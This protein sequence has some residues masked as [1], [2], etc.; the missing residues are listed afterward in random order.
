MIRDL[1]ISIV[2]YNSDAVQLQNCLLSALSPQAQPNVV[3]IDNS[4]TER[5]KALVTG[6]GAEY[7]RPRTNVGFGAGHNLAIRRYLGLHKYHLVLNPD[8]YFD[9]GALDSLV[10]YMD[11][12]PQIGVVIPRVF[13][14][15]G[16]L[17]HLSKLLPTP[18][19]LFFRRF[20]PGPLKRLLERRADVYEFRNFD[21][22]RTLTVPTLS[23]CFMFLRTNVFSTIG[24]FDERY[25]MYLEDVDLCRRIHREYDVVYYPQVSVFHEYAKGSYKNRS[26]LMHHVRS[27]CKYFSKWGWFFDR[28]RDLINQKA[29]SQPKVHYSVQG[30]EAESKPHSIE[31]NLCG[32]TEAWGR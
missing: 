15:D 16:R 24:L 7:L 28:E 8:V 13:Y 18:V 29:L 4:E 27:A 10:E 14:P 12:N 3:V 9:P 26:L 1:V 17:Q 20:S 2:V 30:S 23:G 22:M 6:T 25:F 32:T 31:R 21:P 11:A 5:L 19:D